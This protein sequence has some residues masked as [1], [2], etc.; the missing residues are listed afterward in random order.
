[1]QQVEQRNKRGE[2]RK[3]KIAENESKFLMVLRVQERSGELLTDRQGQMSS[4]GLNFVANEVERVNRKG[5]EGE[6]GN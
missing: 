3:R 2:E 5:R 4:P 1:M 6:I